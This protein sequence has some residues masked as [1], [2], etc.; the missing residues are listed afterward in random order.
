MGMQ[1]S[2]QKEY[3][4][5]E[6]SIPVPMPTP[7]GEAVRGAKSPIAAEALRVIEGQ[8]GSNKPLAGGKP[9]EGQLPAGQLPEGSLEN[10][11]QGLAKLAAEAGKTIE[12]MIPTV[13]DI[14]P[15]K[16]D[17]AQLSQESKGELNVKH[18]EREIE[19]ASW[20]T[21]LRWLPAQGLDLASQIRELANIYTHLLEDIIEYVP[22]DRQQ[23]YTE[24]LRQILVCQLDA[25]I[26][27]SIP[28]LKSFFM[29]YGVENSICRLEKSMYFA[30]TGNY[31]SLE[32]VK[33]DWDAV[34]RAGKQ[35]FLPGKQT[36][37]RK[38]AFFRMNSS[39][40]AGSVYSKAGTATKQAAAAS[41]AE[42]LLNA[43][44]SVQRGAAGQFGSSGSYKG[45]LESIYPVQDIQRGEKFIK[46]LG[47]T[48][49]NLF[50]THSFSAKNESLYGVLWTMEKSKTELFVTRELTSSPLKRDIEASVERMTAA[51]IQNAAAQ[52]S[53]DRIYRERMPV[54]NQE[55]VYE[56]YRYAMKRYSGGETI[57]K[58]IKDGF[59]YALKYFLQSKDGTE[60]GEKRPGFF[61]EFLEKEPLKQDLEKGSKLLED[62]WKHFLSEMGYDDKLLELTASLYG[63][64][65]ALIRP[66]DEKQEQPS[67]KGE[68]LAI[69]GGLAAIA[70]LVVLGILFL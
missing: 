70:V 44:R 67:K 8:G 37:I 55:Q 33:R 14:K 31:L 49:H 58:A 3:G 43:A 63:P 5:T 56:I 20:K 69:A 4:K 18:W 64:W 9:L 48:K 16:K 39:E 54:F 12:A 17:L 52:C 62:D 45:R 47:G 65:A 26:K 6:R 40:G 41:S 30:V 34:S 29:A 42:T 61:Q 38:G 53:H 28:E 35:Y 46:A 2:P 1:I 13:E 19:L 27:I 51:Y 32:T 21:L 25:L 60:S 36:A 57:N 50:T 66:E 24:K 22:A 59:Y 7:G 11:G 10:I 23:L 68:A 15:E